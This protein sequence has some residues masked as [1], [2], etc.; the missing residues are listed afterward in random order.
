MAASV[1]INEP[2]ETLRGISTTRVD[3]RCR[4]HKKRR[5]EEEERKMATLAACVT[6]NR[7]LFFLTDGIRLLKSVSAFDC[8]FR[9]KRI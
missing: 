2:I 4:R 7:A 1:D 9:G 5:E 6:Q 8:F 3:L